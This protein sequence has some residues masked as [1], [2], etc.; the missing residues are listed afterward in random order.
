MKVGE[1]ESRE[2]RSEWRCG[3]GGETGE[4]GRGGSR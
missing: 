4:R 1:R 2:E 3:S